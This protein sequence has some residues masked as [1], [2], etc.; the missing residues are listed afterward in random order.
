VVLGEYDSMSFGA[1]VES[2]LIFFKNIQSGVLSRRN[3]I[4]MASINAGIILSTSCCTA[5]AQEPEFS[6]YPKGQVLLATKKDA[7]E[8]GI[9]G[10]FAGA[11]VSSSKTIIKYPL[12]TATVRLQM[13]KTPY[14]I[15]RPFELFE[16]CFRGVLLPL[17]SNAP[18]GAIFFAVKDASKS[19]LLSAGYP[20]WAATSI[21][22]AAALPPY[23]LIRNPSEVIKTRQQ[24]GIDGY[25]QNVFEVVRSLAN[26]TDDISSSKD[27]YT[28]YFE[29]ILYAY[30]ADVFK[31]LAY[32]S[33]S[34]GRKNLSPSEGALYGAI[35][36]AIAQLLTTPLDVV[37]NR[38]MA[39][40][41]DSDT[42]KHLSYVNSLYTIVEEE[43][44]ASLWSGTSPR[45]GKAIL[46]G[47]IQ[48][49]AYEETK[50]SI[51]R[52][53]LKKI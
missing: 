22:V 4:S 47:A 8:E 27:L 50:S 46:S 35:S 51:S 38:A 6:T 42:D 30:P 23:W 43:G 41:D 21:A 7:S 48:F 49:A 45:V 34:G 25:D 9:S 37:R 36:T 20:K 29:N 28:G 15:S 24:A 17:L 26:S 39:A 12:D 11:A 40:K 10:L 5:S 53:F 1:T 2:L 32:D 14:S 44:L 19:A 13:P 31:F 3:F 18:G 52:M 33:L 16:G